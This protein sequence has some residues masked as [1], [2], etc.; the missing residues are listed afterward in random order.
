MND[1][2]KALLDRIRDA[3]QVPDSV[4]D[5]TLLTDLEKNTNFVQ[6]NRLAH[7]LDQ[8][9]VAISELFWSDFNRAKSYIIKKKN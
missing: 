9:V 1:K 2:D 4:S 3:W 5:E 7:A 6:S 8:V